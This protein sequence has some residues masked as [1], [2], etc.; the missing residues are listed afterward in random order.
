M[1]YEDTFSALSHPLRQKILLSLRDAPAS[2]G[3]L[4]EA[5]PASQPV[6]SQ[7]LRTLSEAG[8]VSVTAQ[9]NRRIYALEPSALLQLK[10]FIETEWQALFDDIRNEATHDD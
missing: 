3:A 2:V 8:L 5:L 9:G 4:T 1:P 7:H 10:T 6:I